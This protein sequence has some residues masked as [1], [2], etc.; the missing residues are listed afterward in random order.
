MGRFAVLLYTA[1]VAE[2][3]DDEHDEHAAD[4][5]ATGWLVAAFALRPP[6]T[7]PHLGL[8]R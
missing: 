3:C 5:A 4:L 1:H 6:G 8:P 7:G 2:G